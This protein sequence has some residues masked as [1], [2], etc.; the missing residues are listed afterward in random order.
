MREDAGSAKPLLSVVMATYNRLDLLRRVLGYL[1][2]QTLPSDQFE[3]IVVDDGSRLPVSE[4]LDVSQYSF[5]LKLLRQDNSGPSA[6]RHNGAKLAAGDILLFVDDDMELPPGF[7][8]AHLQYHKG[9][10]P[11]AVIGRYISDPAIGS[12]SLFERY[13]GVKWDKTTEL[14][15]QGQLQIDGTFLATGNTSMR[16]SDYFRVG[17]LDTSLPRAEDMALGLDLEAAGVQLVYSETA[18]SVHLSDH[19]SVQKWMDRAYLHGRLECRIAEKHPD[20]AHADPWRFMFSLPLVGR[21]LCI[22]SIVAPRA[23]SALADSMYRA[24]EL[25][26]KAGFEKP[27]LRATGLVF[28]M[29]YF[30]GFRDEA[31]SLK[32]MAN[33]CVTFLKKVSVSDRQIPGVPKWIAQLVAVT[34]K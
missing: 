23:G 16:R 21:L 5:A 12:K 14:V 33:D 22:P 24:A 10:R 13:H 31:G 18:G 30:C 11:T 7:L 26:D 27:A 6:A 34:T 28:G 8:Q 25:V 15:R 29:K 17:G 19:T 9:G 1:A 3:V 4:H 20:M 2:D 32:R